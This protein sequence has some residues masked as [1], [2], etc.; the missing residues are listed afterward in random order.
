MAFRALLG[1]YAP[2]P[3]LT[4]GC[5][6]RFSLRFSVFLGSSTVGWVQ[7]KTADLFPLY[8]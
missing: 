8:C 3:A 6:G 4:S 7:D 5:K 1:A 2:C